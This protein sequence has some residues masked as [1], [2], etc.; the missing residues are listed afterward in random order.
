VHVNTIRYCTLRN[1]LLPLMLAILLPPITYE[2]AGARDGD[3][4]GEDGNGDGAGT[5]NGARS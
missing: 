3:G 1:N 2:C 5:G 4:D